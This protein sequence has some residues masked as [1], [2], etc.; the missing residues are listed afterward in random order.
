[1]R[2]LKGG[3]ECVWDVWRFVDVASPEG[4]STLSGI[5]ADVVSRF[6]KR[7]ANRVAVVLAYPACIL[8]PFVRAPF[9]VACHRAGNQRL[10]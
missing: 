5:C 8:P 9:V 10:P 1:M 2:N 6:T 4:M 7:N 3:V